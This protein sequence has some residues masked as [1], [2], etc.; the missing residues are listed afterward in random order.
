[1]VTGPRDIK[2]YC[3]KCGYNLTGLTSAQCPECGAA[4]D[5]EAL[6]QAR[7]RPWYMEVAWGIGT[8][9]LAPLIAWICVVVAYNL[10]RH[11]FTVGSHFALAVG[12]IIA[13]G[14]AVTGSAIRGRWVARRLA[15]KDPG[16]P[17]T[18]ATVAMTVLYAGAALVL[19]F[20]LVLFVA[21]ATFCA[22][23]PAL[24]H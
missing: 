24:G 12:A 3:P 6:R 11:G 20:V 4:Y 17:A 21:I 8:F 9:L 23:I 15:R 19:Q 13:L 10:D 16:D 1:M 18:P 5:L 7:R 22:L 14:V 2:L